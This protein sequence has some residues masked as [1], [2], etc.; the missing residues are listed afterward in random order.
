[1][2]IICIS[3]CNENSLLEEWLSHH[4]HI[5]NNNKALEIILKNL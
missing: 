1:M 4:L 2:Y 5:K 3:L